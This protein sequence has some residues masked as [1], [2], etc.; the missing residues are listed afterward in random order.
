MWSDYHARLHQLLKSRHILP[1]G[2]KILVALSGGQDSLCLTRLILDLQ[3]KWGWQVAIAHC[4]HNW[5]LDEGLGEHIEGIV[6]EWGVNLYL[7]KATT[8]I[9]EKEAAARKW[10]YQVLTDIAV[11]HGFK[12]VVTGHTKSDRTETFLY[13]LI[14]GAG[15]DGLTSLYWTRK[16]GE[17]I[18]L[19]RPLL[20]F[21]RQ[22][23]GNFCQK[24]Q[25]PIWEDSYNQNKKFVRNRIRLDLIPYLQKEFNPQVE[26][27]IAH[28]AEILRA[29]RE[30]LDTQ[31]RQLFAEAI[32]N[33]DTIDREKLKHQP[34]S[35]QRRVVKL[36]LGQILP[37]MPSFEQIEEVVKLIDAPNGSQTSS[38]AKVGAIAV[39]DDY[40][41]L[42]Q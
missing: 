34:L 2:S 19:V 42:R 30:F 39:K 35:L 36:F 10:R 37:K 25:L 28:T 6:H 11:S 14:R 15:S 22:D 21:S 20:E 1:K 40:I 24:F 13:N 9:P 3:D 38:F 17:D 5:E 18:E 8:A 33:K 32:I 31:A 41:T 27:H 7:E 29:D 4:D 26:K 16:L 23:T 12:Y